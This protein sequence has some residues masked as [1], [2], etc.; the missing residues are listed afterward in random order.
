MYMRINDC[1]IVTFSCLSVCEWRKDVVVEDKGNSVSF[2]GYM[3]GD[4]NKT[5]Y[6]FNAF[7][8]V[9]E[10]IIKMNLRKGSRITVIA[11]L[12]TFI[13][14]DNVICNSYKVYLID[15]LPADDNQITAKADNT[16]RHQPQTPKTQESMV[17]S[18]VVTGNWKQQESQTPTSSGKYSYDMTEVNID[19]FANAVGKMSY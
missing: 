1:P 6:T 14:K 2:R 7:D 17:N 9:R 10:R 3:P 5:N 15:Y 16:S 4:K 18:N 13:N 12:K 8:D 19:E 11:A